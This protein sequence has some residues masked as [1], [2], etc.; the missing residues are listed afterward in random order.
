MAGAAPNP[1]A[2]LPVQPRANGRP[3]SEFDGSSVNGCKSVIQAWLDSI[4]GNEPNPETL[5]NIPGQ[6]AMIHTMQLPQFAQGYVLSSTQ[7]NFA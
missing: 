2:R 6:A 4:D 5:R 3:F 7:V 1:A